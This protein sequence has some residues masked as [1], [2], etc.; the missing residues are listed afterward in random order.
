M[1]SIPVARR[2]LSEANAAL[3]DLQAG[4]VVGRAILVP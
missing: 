3:Q 1:K 2:P 4:R